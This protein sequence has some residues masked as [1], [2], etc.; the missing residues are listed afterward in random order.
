MKFT[1]PSIEIIEQKPGLQGVYEQ[2]EMAG[3]TCYASTHIIKRDDNGN[4]LTA[5]KF[6]N[7]MID[8]KHYA[9]LEHGTI[10]LKIDDVVDE[11]GRVSYNC[12][13]KGNYS[14]NPY[15]KKT[16][17]HYEQ[18]PDELQSE[19]CTKIPR[20][21]EYIST[22]MRVLVE[23]GWLDDLKFLCEPTEHHEK[24]VTVKFQTDRG[25][26]AEG[27]RHKLLCVA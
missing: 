10:Y 1:T 15:S 7:R 19:F 13:L 8:S 21:T 3:R 23:N 24:R 22:N 9:M 11:Y 25:V 14:H 12:N 6:V 17:V 4:S 27:N 26:S 16:C 18:E 5:E 20:T 2:I